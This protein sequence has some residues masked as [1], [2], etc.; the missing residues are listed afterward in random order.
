MPGVLSRPAPG[1]VAGATGRRRPPRGPRRARLLDRRDVWTLLPLRVFLGAT[2]VSTGLRQLAD[3][4][5]LRGSSAA[6]VQ[7]Q[8]HHA[9]RSIGALSALAHHAAL[10]GVIVVLA[11]IAIGL[12]T[13]LGLWARPT[14]AA[15]VLVSLALAVTLTRPLSHGTDLVLAFAFT[16]LVI[17]GA[18]PVSV[19]AAALAEARRRLDLPASQSVI[20]EFEAVRQLCG[21]YRDGGCTA[22]RDRRCAPSGCP[23]LALAPAPAAVAEV[24]RRAFLQRAGIAGW[25]GAAAVVGGGM[26]AL[27]GRVAPS[28][29]AKTSSPPASGAGQA[30]LQPVPTTAAAGGG[31]D[32]PAGTL[33][34][35]TDTL[36]ATAPPL[37]TAPTPTTAPPV[38]RPAP[39]PAGM[40]TLGPTSAVPVGGAAAFTD[41]STGDPGFVVQ[42]A[43]GEFLAFDATCTHEGCPVRYAGATFTCPCHGAQ[44]DSATGR[45]LK[46]PASSPL[47]RIELKVIGSTLYAG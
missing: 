30:G 11:E 47:R 44:F 17:G 39:A 6:S 40:T 29:P 35:P 2:L 37:S 28:R 43:T 3:R 19:D 41:P 1:G 34:A 31:L 10:V 8:L 45:V 42:P 46:G 21:A 36:A 15:G 12:A 4:S 16:P 23:A 27:V 18:G 38:S 24:N 25:V 20:V 32:A 33:A 26:A 14:A 5:F 22:R 7:A 9:A 13:L